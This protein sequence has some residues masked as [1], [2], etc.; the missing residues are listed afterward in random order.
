MKLIIL[1]LFL[2]AFVFI[3]SCENKNTEENSDK[4]TN[5]SV[6]KINNEGNIDISYTD[7]V[8]Y[9]DFFVQHQ[10]RLLKMIIQ[11]GDVAKNSTKEEINDFL[12]EMIELCESSIKEIKDV[13]GFKGSTELREAALELFSFY[14]RIMKKQYKEMFEIISKEEDLITEED[15]DKMSA[16]DKSVRDE[17]KI[18]DEIYQKAQK[19]FTEKHNLT[20]QDRDM[21][22]EIDNLNSWTKEEMNEFMTACIGGV[23]ENSGIDAEAYCSCMAEKIMKKYP[24]PIDV[25]KLTELEIEKMAIGCVK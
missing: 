17:E 23:D 22:G 9:G 15:I 19:K 25:M 12:D 18:Y 21:Q 3:T 14:S 6:E 11:I 4:N 24:N 10:N 20:L 7:P 13:K 1:S 16:I 8:K 5:D 2:S